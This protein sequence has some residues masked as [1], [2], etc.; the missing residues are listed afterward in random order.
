MAAERRLRL[1]YLADP[2]SVHTRR[3]IAFFADAGH[4][5]LLLDGHGTEISPGLPPGVRVERFGPHPRRW[6]LLPLR[7]RAELR[8]L[9][10]RVQPDVLHAHYVRRFGWQAALSGFHPYVVSPW[11]SDVLLSAGP[12]TRWWNRRALRGADLVTVTSNHI[13]AAV[14]AAGGRADRVHL[15]QHGIE[16][17]VFA[18][19]PPDAALAERLGFAGRRVVFSPRAIRPLYRHQVVLQAFARLPADTLLLMTAAGADPEHRAELQEQAA[20]LEVAD[21]VRIV[22]AI[23][24]G[25]MPAYLRL[26]DVMVSVPESDS[27]PVSVQ[28]AMAC[29]VPVVASDLPAARAVLGQIAPGALVPVGDVDAL[30]G[31][32]RQ[33][34]ELDGARRDAIGRTFREHVEASGDYRSNMEHMESLYRDL[35]AATGRP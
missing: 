25:E 29:G 27:F 24:Y 6:P 15:V 18:P 8:G 12:R 26:A 11:G 3:W 31:A 16:T 17:D 5:V 21:R 13:R 1:A 14:L 20:R 33:A 4:E 19:G 2:N 23:P 35:V 32:L 30:A 22:E 28:E 10:A 34:L 7:L 9:V